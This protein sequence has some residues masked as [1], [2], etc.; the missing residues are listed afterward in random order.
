M[1]VEKRGDPEGIVAWRFISHRRP[2]RHRGSGARVRR[3]RSRPIVSVDGD[4]ERLLQRPHP[5]RRRERGHHLQQGQSIT[6]AR[7]IPIRTGHIIGA[8]VG[9]S[10]PDARDRSGHDRAPRVDLVPAAAGRA[11]L[12]STRHVFDQRRAGWPSARRFRVRDT[13]TSPASLRRRNRDASAFGDSSPS[14][15]TA[16]FTYIF[17]ANAWL[18]DDAYIT[19]RVVWN[20]LHGYGAGLQPGRARAGV[21]ASAVVAGDD[22][23]RTR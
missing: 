16:A 10:G 8:P 23:A 20:C 2:D 6:R 7:T 19:F 11:E 15:L 17:L 13:R 9:R 14:V 22:R 5:A 21:H 4:V 3:L 18:G 12:T 1:T